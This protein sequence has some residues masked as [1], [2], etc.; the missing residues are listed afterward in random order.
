MLGTALGIFDG[1]SLDFW[2]GEE[3]GTIEGTEEGTADGL[4]LGVKLGKILGLD[5]GESLGT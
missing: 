2:L 4:S 5:D 1:I 3:L